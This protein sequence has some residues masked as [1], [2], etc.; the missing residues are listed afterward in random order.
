MS[1]LLDGD[2]RPTGVRIAERAGVSRRAL[3]THF[4]DREEL[5]A[6]AGEKTLRLQYADAGPLTTDGTVT[7]RV[8][9]FSRRRARMLEA[10]AGISRA[11]QLWLPFSAQIRRNRDRHTAHHR[12]EIE[13][14][15]AP[16]LA[17]EGAR[18]DRL[19]HALLTASS[20]PAWSACRDDLGLGVD[21]AEAVL[22]DTL[23]ALLAGAPE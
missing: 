8:A 23:T 20:W 11:A 7:E 1:L 13:E 22:R 5:F 4:A 15:F 2:L 10:I 14:M 12:A 9:R 18:R 3:W 6:A 17:R 16:E 21:D 19:L